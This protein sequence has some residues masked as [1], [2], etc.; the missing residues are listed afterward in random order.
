[1]R[2]FSLLRGVRAGLAWRA[3]SPW[4]FA[5]GAGLSRELAFRAGVAQ[6]QRRDL[7]LDL[8]LLP[9]Q[10][11]E[12]VELARAFPQTQF[13]LDHLATLELG[14]PET[15]Q[16]WRAGITALASFSNVSI[17]LS[18]LWTIS[19][20]WHIDALRDPIRHVVG[21][22]GPQRCMWGSNLPIEKLMCDAATQIATLRTILGD[23]PAAE[24]AEIFANTARRIYRIAGDS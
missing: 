7:S 9:E 13:I 12:V 3:N 24:Q 15:R 20:P 22:F 23:Y 17:K 2:A 19:R 10:L 1:M 18:G 16:I 11:P 8:I 6:L 4:R 5:A 21:S 14:S